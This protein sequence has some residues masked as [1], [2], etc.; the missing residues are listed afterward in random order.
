MDYDNPH[1]ELPIAFKEF[2]AAPRKDRRTYLPKIE[3]IISV[4]EQHNNDAYLSEKCAGLIHACKNLSRLLQPKTYDES[5]EI[6]AA[7][8]FIS[9]ILDVYRG[10]PNLSE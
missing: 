3:H 5:R 2:L 8:G 10:S 7:L 4:I 9:K 1:N 6:S